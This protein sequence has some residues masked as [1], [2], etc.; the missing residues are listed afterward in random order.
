MSQTSSKLIAI[1]IFMAA[2]LW[3]GSGFI[4]VLANNEISIP[5]SKKKTTPT[6]SVEILK[7][8]AQEIWQQV[9]LYGITEGNRSVTLKSQTHGKVEKINFLEGEY[10]KEGDII[11]SLAIEDRKKNLESAEALL[12]QRQ[13]EYNV[14]KSLKNSGHQ[15]KT[16][17][18]EAKANLKSAEA[19]LARIKTA[20]E[21][22]FITAPFDGILQEL[23]VEIGDFI[24]QSG[25]SVATILDNSRIIAVGQVPEKKISGIK[26][27][28]NAR[29]R[30]VN[31]IITT[32][33]VSYISKIADPV[34]RTFKVEIE[35]DNDSQDF[36]EGM[37]TEIV[38]PTKKVMSHVVK[39]SYFAF[40]E[41]GE[42]GIKTIEGNNKVKFN[43]IEI[44]KEDKQGVWITGLASN[45]NIITLG[46]AY[47]KDGDV[48]K[49]AN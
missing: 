42:I 49:I 29:I 17:L 22:I 25:E 46:Q 28:N 2:F 12:Q 33:M 39:S 11:L 32:G 43:P 45:A 34:T 47:L 41:S 21:N 38:I 5:I 44:I 10:V 18:S 1:L 26:I 15:S 6:P 8:D 4:P 16:K 24:H 36:F 14:A 30:T 9:I 23:S 13:L 27:G 48:A 7:S 35:A 37:T 19:N 31:E 40:D 20:F 3:M